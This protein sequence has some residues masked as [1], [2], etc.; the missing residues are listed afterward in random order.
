MK[1]KT[2]AITTTL[3]VTLNVTTVQAQ[4]FESMPSLYDLFLSYSGGGKGD[5]PL[6]Q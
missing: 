1:L 4:P 6:S 2:L 3:L 5:D